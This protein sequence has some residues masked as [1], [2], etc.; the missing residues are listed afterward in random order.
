M[1][2]LLAVTFG[3]IGAFL[4]L[5]DWRKGIFVCI[6]V[7]FIQDPLRKLVEGEPIS[8]TAL[9]AIFVLLTILGAWM[10]GKRLKLRPIPAWNTGLRRPI[11][12]FA[13]LV[14]LQSVAAFLS[15]GSIAVAGIGLLAYLF[16]I[17]PLLLSYYYSRKEKDIDRFIRF[18]LFIAM[19]MTSGIYLSY[20]GVDWAVLR[21]VGKG[22][23][24]YAPSGG[25]LKLHSGF[26]RAPE[27]AAWHAGTAICMII[28]LLVTT[29]R[30]LSFRLR[31]GIMILFFLGAMMLT[32]RRKV[33]IEIV[34]FISVYG[35]LLAYFRRGAIKLAV[36]LLILGISSAVLG[37]SYLFKDEVLTGFQPYLQREASVQKEATG[38]LYNMTI[39]SFRWV[40][41]RNGVLGSGAGT[42]SQGV[43]H[44]IGDSDIVGGAAEGGLGKILAELGVPGL[45]LFL[46]MGAALIRYLWNMMVSIRKDDPVSSRLVYG[47]ASFLIAN[48]AIFVIAHQV[49]GDPFVLMII[50]WML[51]FLFAVESSHPAMSKRKD[52]GV[53]FV[54]MPKLR[55]IPG[56]MKGGSIKN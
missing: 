22:I 30:T 25:I 44:F 28:L 31:S 17:P 5:M 56:V 43:Q 26:L 21:Q 40:M 29:R 35:F 18:Y 14:F 37:N 32:G 6:I 53:N 50:G 16:P 20:M 13:A 41:S 8:L 4:C 2:E 54:T 45:I 27:T 36:L 1:I 3:L 15:T 49:F 47:I 33:L 48:G 46:W 7:G 51:G 9:V 34:L 52:G 39:G 12:W 42:G 24:A 11:I 19:I 38:R 23:L 10:S 55:Y